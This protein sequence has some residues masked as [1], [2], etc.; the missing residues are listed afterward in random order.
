VKQLM[1]LS[2]LMA[3]ASFSRAEDNLKQ[4]LWDQVGVELRKPLFCKC[5]EV[6]NVKEGSLAQKLGMQK[7]DRWL[8]DAEWVEISVSSTVVLGDDE[9]AQLVGM[10]RDDGKFLP[11]IV[12]GGGNALMQKF[13]V[14]E[15]EVLER[16][17]LKVVSYRDNELRGD[18]QLL[19]KRNSEKKKYLLTNGQLFSGVG[20]HIQ[21]SDDQ[22]VLVVEVMPGLPA[23][24]SGLQSGDKII[25]VNNIYVKE[26]SEFVDIVRSQP[27]GAELSLKVQRDK[28][29]LVDILIKTT[30]MKVDPEGF[31]N[32]TDEE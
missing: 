24:K 20:V 15:I 28:N 29:Q 17:L 19:R 31:I 9:F 6:K 30:V 18:L 10:N 3:S 5:V 26:S 22:G 21:S 32:A 4:Q 14:K 2:L 13:P 1:I 25:S 8:E 23:E 11:V 16:A 7:G 27:L 12:L